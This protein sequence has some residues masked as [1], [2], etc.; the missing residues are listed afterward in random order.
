MMTACA[1]EDGDI[2]ASGTT[3]DEQLA[4]AETAAEE[5][6]VKPTEIPQTAPLDTAPQKGGK[7][8]F[9]ENGSPVTAIIGDAVEEAAGTIGWSYGDVSYEPA[10][11]ATLQSALRTALAQKPTAVVVTGVSPDLYGAEPIA[12]YKKAGVPIVA[13]GVCLTKEYEFPIIQGPAGCD[14][15]EAVGKLVADWVTADSEG[16]AKILHAHLPIFPSYVA[17]KGGFEDEVKATCPG[18]SLKTISLTAEQLAAGQVV[19]TVVSTLRSNPDIDYIVFD[20]AQNA[21]GLKSA[22]DAAGIEDIKWGGRQGD[23]EAIGALKNGEDNAWTA[24]SYPVLGY[25][26][27]DTALR[28]LGGGQ[29]ADANLF[30][31]IQLLTKDNAGD[32]QAPYNEP[33]DALDQYKALWNVS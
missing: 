29:G 10:N 22:L 11:P 21:A 25:A 6:S 17:M 33:R 18:C 5:A 7:V 2:S 4:A 28:S 3:S 31:P 27:I 19:P 26:A 15:E 30:I 14:Q 16:K 24:S 1:S 20:Q 23:E 13:S 12:A 32:V 9:F 8:I